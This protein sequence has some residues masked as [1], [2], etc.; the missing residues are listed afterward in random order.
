[1]ERHNRLARFLRKKAIDCLQQTVSINNQ[2]AAVKSIDI[3][4]ES[5]EHSRSDHFTT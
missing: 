1:M 3:S 5:T 2:A 4:H